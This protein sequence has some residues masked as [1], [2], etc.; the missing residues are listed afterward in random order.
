MTVQDL[1]QMNSLENAAPDER[2]IWFKVLPIKLYKKYKGAC[3]LPQLSMNF[4]DQSMISCFAA[5]MSAEL[6]ENSTFL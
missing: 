5:I 1:I 2:N 3:I 4:D 6:S